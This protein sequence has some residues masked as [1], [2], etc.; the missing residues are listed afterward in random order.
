MANLNPGAPVVQPP[1]RLPYPNSREAPRFDSEKPE[2]LLRFLDQLEEIFVRCGVQDHAQ[3]KKEAGKYADTVTERQWQG[4]ETYAAG[5]TWEEHKKEIIAS[6]SE[7]SHLAKGSIGVLKRIC[8]ENR[9]IG[10]KDASELKSFKRKFQGEVSKLI[11]PALAGTPPPIVT[12]RELTGMV[13]DCFEETFRNAV[14]IRLDSMA[15]AALAPA[16]RSAEDPYLLKDVWTAAERIA[17]SSSGAYSS[18]ILSTAAPSTTIKT[19]ESPDVAAAVARLQDTFVLTQKQNQEM[20]SLMMKNM[21]QM[22]INQNQGSRDR[23]SGGGN[24]YSNNPPPARSYDKSQQDHNHASSDLCYHCT[25]PG[26]IRTNC[27]ELNRQHAEKKVKLDAN[28]RLRLYD[29]SS[30]PAEPGVSLSERIENYY[31]RKGSV[32]QNIMSYDGSISREEYNAYLDAFKLEAEEE[33]REQTHVQ[34]LQRESKLKSKAS[35]M[36]YD[37]D[38]DDDE[39][40]DFS[41]IDTQQLKKVMGAKLLKSFVATRGSKGEDF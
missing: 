29:G 17:D 34:L 20:M 25:L 9:R 8:A 35:A 41:T 36:T 39:D 15:A 27:P 14:R 13:L 30:I 6:Y 1:A 2:E 19:E 26:H 40:F 11:P 33:I 3:K 12:N 16:E 38:S 28:G 22:H 21:A 10:I 18:A 4:M 24:N 7:A 31:K 23:G 5:S 37:S 32:S